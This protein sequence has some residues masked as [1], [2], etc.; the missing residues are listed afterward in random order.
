LISILI[1]FNI[2]R[3]LNV[4]D[5]AVVEFFALKHPATKQQKNK[6]GLTALQIAEKQGFKR[7]A[8]VLINGQ[9]APDSLG[10]NQSKS[11][12]P[13]HTKEELT[14]AAKNG[15]LILIKDF[16]VDRYESREE[17]R[18][19]CFQLI[20]V[21]QKA[22]Q[23]EV[24][25]ILQ[26]YYDKQLN[27]ELP[28]DIETGTV[29][30]LN[31]HYKKILLGFLT[32]LGRVIAESSVVL[33]PADPSTYQDLF[34]NM[35]ANQ[36]KSSQEIHKVD[37]ERDA[38]KL[39]E[40][41]MAKIN[42]KL[43]NIDSELSKLHEE[44]ETLEKNMQETSEQL[45]SQENITA[46]QR[47]DLFKQQEEHKKQLAVY[48]CSIF[49]YELQ[50]EATLNRRNTVKFIRENPNMY[51]FFRTI[52]NLLQALFHGALAARS[53]LFTMRKNS[54][55]GSSA[56]MSET[57]LTSII[58][59]CKCNCVSSVKRNYNLQQNLIPRDSIGQFRSRNFKAN[60]LW[61]RVRTNYDFQPNWPV[62]RY[63]SFI[64]FLA[65]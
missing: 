55:V 27:A 2:F 5:Y 52:E 54:K 37:S 57:V 42:E 15:H 65:L 22:K 45:K 43:T 49:L 61:L 21:A 24:I 39:S 64:A 1:D 58:P 3:F 20:N 8:Y 63:K 38:K 4:G 28:S 6:A 34:S 13:K 35:T 7:I 12:G 18:K 44:K 33:D 23:H 51:L 40:Q 30:R 59:I 48:E 26:P 16:L 11:D 47:Q 46:I 62:D 36:R 29:I 56:K 31:Q 60:M 53:G 25:G 41:D 32:G 9:P 19:I 10:E 14:H 17:K 50:Q